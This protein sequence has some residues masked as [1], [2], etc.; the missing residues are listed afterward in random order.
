MLNPILYSN[1][2]RTVVLID[3]PTSIAEAQGNKHCSTATVLLSCK[4][5][6]E[7]FVIRNEPKSENAIAS[8]A[9]NTVERELHQQYLAFILPALDEIRSARPSPWCIERTLLEP[10]FEKLSLHPDKDGSSSERGPDSPLVNDAQNVSIELNL[11]QTISALRGVNL[12]WHPKFTH[13]MSIS[14]HHSSTK[15]KPKSQEPWQPWACVFSNDKKIPMQLSIQECDNHQQ[16]FR[17]IIP[18]LSSFILNDV[19]DVRLFRNI[20]PDLGIPLN[21]FDFV[22]LDPPWPNASARRKGEYNAFRNRKY[23]EGKLRGLNFTKLLAEGGYVGIWITSKSAIR[24]FVVGEDGLF[25]RHRIKLVEEWIWLKVTAKGEPFLSLDSYW[26]KPY[27][28]LLLGQKETLR[29]GEIDLSNSRN[30]PT[31]K[32]IAGVPDFHSRKPCLRSLIEPM[33]PDPDNYNAMELFARHLTA[34]WWSLGD[35]VLKYNWEGYWAG[36]NKNITEST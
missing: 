20:L 14:V 9:N 32:V 12:T 30:Q 8:A 26:R 10:R 3:I 4:A 31:K 28:I 2:D 23:L 19:F 25:R 24:K 17:F 13:L 1:T 5:Y 18:P 22:L 36:Q 34:G 33:M 27:E 15:D 11:K 7:P 16:Q 6:E 21:Y 35:E 29:H